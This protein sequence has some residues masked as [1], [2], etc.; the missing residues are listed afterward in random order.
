V[1]V[2]N[3]KGDQGRSLERRNPFLGRL[4]LG[5]RLR[6]G[7]PRG[8]LPLCGRG[9]TSGLPGDRVQMLG[10]VLSYQWRTGA[11][12]R[13][14]RLHPYARPGDGWANGSGGP[15]KVDRLTLIR[16]GEDFRAGPGPNY[17][18][19]LNTVSVRGSRAF[20]A[21]AGRVKIA[22]LKSF[23]GG[24]NYTLPPD[25]EP[26]VDLAKFHTVTIWCESFSV[27]IGS[28]VLPKV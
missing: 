19:Y 4:K 9:F 21:D 17:W 8:D 3:L 24:R 20:T 28:A 5:L 16:F 10:G 27:Y 15:Y 1:N 6:L 7:L 14:R 12:A 23:T 2:A 11:Q 18:V 13:D 22:Q 25:V 26:D